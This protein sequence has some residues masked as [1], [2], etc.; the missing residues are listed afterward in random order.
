MWSRFAEGCL[1]CLIALEVVFWRKLMWN[2][3]PIRDTIIRG[4]Y[5]SWQVVE[6][7]ESNGKTVTRQQNGRARFVG[8]SVDSYCPPRAR[9][10]LKYR[11]TENWATACCKEWRCGRILLIVGQV[12]EGIKTPFSGCGTVR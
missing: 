6:S 12:N 7:S 11:A 2:D 3:A 5:R 8:R 1:W 9:D 10:V 4:H